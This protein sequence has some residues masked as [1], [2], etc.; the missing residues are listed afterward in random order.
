MNDIK[1]TYTAL[2]AEDEP[3]LAE[4]LRKE[5]AKTW[6]DLHVQNVVSNGTSALELLQTTQTDVAFL[7][8][9]MPGLTGLQVAESLSK[10]REL[11]SHSPLPVIVFVTAYEEHAI[12]AFEIQALDYVRKPVTA[13]RLTKTVDRIK[14]QL[15][16]R[17][18]FDLNKIAKQ[19][20]ETIRHVPNVQQPLTSIRAA[21]GNTTHLIATADIIYFEASDKYVNVV[22]HQG[23]AII[24]EP[25]K[26]LL[27]TLD[28]NQFQQIHR[29]YIVN[30]HYVTSAEKLEDAKLQLNLKDYPTQ[31]PVS[32]LYTH[33]FKPM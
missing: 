25:L 12:D 6:P 5:L 27:A 18:Q 31:L 20:D 23:E 19:L 17:S 21:T 15:F 4:S 7:D 30:M 2:I 13:A 16:Q 28:S 14:E 33:L 11:N 29:S 9:S 22:T 10:D 8:V 3:I 32:R 26:N 24:R 1:T